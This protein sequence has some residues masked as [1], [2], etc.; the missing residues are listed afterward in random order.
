MK[1]NECVSICLKV[2]ALRYGHQFKEIK[3]VK[4]MPI[5]NRPEV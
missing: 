1:E 4:Q 2:S 5:R 3:Y